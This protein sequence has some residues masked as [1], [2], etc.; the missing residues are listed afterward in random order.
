MIE[1]S[2]WKS[3]LTGRSRSIFVK[4]TINQKTETK[5]SQQMSQLKVDNKLLDE[6]S[7]GKELRP[8]KTHHEGGK[9][10]TQEKIHAAIKQ[11]PELSH[12]EPPK[13]GLSEEVKQAYLE[14]KKGK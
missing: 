1:S 3:I 6:I 9:V 12:V 2:F 4:P 8:S 10:L 14:E 7:K 5:T 13:E 11:Q